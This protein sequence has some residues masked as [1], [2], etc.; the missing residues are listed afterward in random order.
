M[1]LLD[2]L[3]F[4]ARRQ[5]Q[6]ALIVV[7]RPVRAA[8]GVVHVG[9]G[10]LTVTPSSTNTMKLFCSQMTAPKCMQNSDLAVGSAI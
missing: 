10:V 8:H 1:R 9:T 6:P 2:Q 3:P 7:R 5:L 4:P